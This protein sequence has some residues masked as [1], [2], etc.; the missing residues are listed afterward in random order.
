MNPIN[1]PNFATVSMNKT[2]P[3]LFPLHELIGKRWSP[4]SF[5]EKT[6]SKESINTLFEAARWAPSAGNEQPWEYIYAQK[7]TPGFDLLWH[8]LAIGNQPWT[9]NAN[10]LVAAIARTTFAKAGKNNH[11]AQHDLGMANAQLVLQAASMD[12]YSHIMGGFDKIKLK[13]VLQL[14]ETQEPVCMIAMGYADAPDKLEEPFR[15]REIAER[16]R[17]P[18]TEF[19]NQI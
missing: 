2:A 3:A 8:C 5:S 9:Q 10:V 14:S 7:G 18:I 4:R 11:F 17:K 15:S 6:I 13:E 19:T 1:Q 12:V 16:V